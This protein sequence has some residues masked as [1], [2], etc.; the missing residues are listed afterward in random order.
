MNDKIDFVIT[1][2]DDSDEKW[3]KEKNKYNTNKITLSNSNVRYRDWE[4]LKYW[5]RGV[6]KYASWVNKIYFVTCGQKPE[7]LNEKNPKLILVNHRDFIPSKYLPTFSANPIELN[8]HNIN[9]L[10]NNFVYFNDDMFIINK[11]SEEDF[12]RKNLPCD[13]YCEIPLFFY[14]NNDVFP[15]ILINDSE[16]I[17][18]NFNK[19]EAFKKNYKKY[20]N[21]KYGFKSN[22]KTIFML[23]YKNYSSFA[24][25]HLPSSLNKQTY[26]DV[27]N[28]EYDKLDEV[29]KNKFRSKNDINQYLLKAWQFC[30]GN[31]YPRRKKIGDSFTISNNNQNIIRNIALSKYK[32]ICLNDSDCIDD[33]EKAKKEINNAFEKKFPNKSAFEK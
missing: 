26:I 21:Y 16:V 24:F 5:F 9:G 25:S 7:W 2:V 13:D 15:H 6:E 33:F 32:M 18:K 27:W 17:N 11:V 8:F 29:C 20:I 30:S 19:S 10:S 3:Q 31:F 28:K 14:G 23:I 4:Q 12:F 1:W 22:I